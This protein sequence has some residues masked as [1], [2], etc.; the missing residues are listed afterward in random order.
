VEASLSHCVADR[1]CQ[2][3]DGSGRPSQLKGAEG[4]R[5]TKVSKRNR[6]I[7]EEAFAAKNRVIHVS[8]NAAR[9]ALGT[10]NRRSPMVPHGLEVQPKPRLC[11][12]H[13]A[14]EYAV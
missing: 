2:N 3:Q 11:G 8:P 13:A 9:T 5:G 4:L 10:E 12:R 1:G 6:T 14:A 7:S